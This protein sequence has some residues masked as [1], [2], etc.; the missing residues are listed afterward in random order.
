[1]NNHPP[2]LYVGIDFGT[3]YTGVSWSTPNQ[4]NYDTNIIKQWPGEAGDEIKVPSVL[5][6][7]LREEKTKWGFLCNNLA[8]HTQWKL[9]KPLLDPEVHRKKLT[10]TEPSSP[11]VPR[12]TDKLHELVT[13]YLRQIC[14]HISEKIPEL[15][16]T[17]DDFSEELKRKT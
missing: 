2:D 16:K 5:A 3:T 1:M 14:T 12:T 6:K 15:I 4:D 9:F 7:D 17:D 11:W 8:D 10:D 13:L